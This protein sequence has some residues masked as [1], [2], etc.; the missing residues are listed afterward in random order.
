LERGGWVRDV[1]GEITSGGYAL[2]VHLADRGDTSAQHV[3]Y[4]SGY[5]ERCG[6]CWLGANHS[7]AAHARKIE[8][9]R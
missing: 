8:E 4:P 2:V 3:T 1:P 9:E 5:D 6:W 7:Q